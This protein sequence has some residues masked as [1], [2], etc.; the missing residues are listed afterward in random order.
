[1]N[2]VE[3]VLPSLEAIRDAAPRPFTIATRE[4][5]ERLRLITGNRSLQ[6][7][8]ASP[9]GFSLDHTAGGG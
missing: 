4:D 7:G 8:D 3:D 6:I 1:M 5:R 2:L 9:V